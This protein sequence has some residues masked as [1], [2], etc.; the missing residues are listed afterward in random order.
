MCNRF[1]LLWNE[2]FHL[3]D[4]ISRHVGW[5]LRYMGR[6]YYTRHSVCTV[7]VLPLMHFMS[8][9]I[10]LFWGIGDNKYPNGVASLLRTT[11]SGGFSIR[12]LY[13][14]VGIGY[15]TPPT[16]PPT[17]VVVCALSPVQLAGRKFFRLERTLRPL[18]NDHPPAQT[19]LFDPETMSNDQPL[20]QTLGVG[21]HRP[22]RNGDPQT[23]FCPCNTKSPGCPSNNFS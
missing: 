3:W 6:V 7:R 8:I 22:P 18:R 16:R 4:D 21:G 10:I 2:V 1:W 19:A 14:T 15:S 23:T 13:V 17:P 11:A 5:K 20:G 9:A 12:W